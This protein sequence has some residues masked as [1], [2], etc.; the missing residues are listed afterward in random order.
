MR[1]PRVGAVSRSENKQRRHDNAAVWGC[2]SVRGSSASARTSART[3]KLEA[4]AAERQYRPVLDDRL[5]ADV[6][7]HL[8]AGL[9]LA[10]VDVE[11]PVGLV[12]DID[13]DVDD[14][15]GKLAPELG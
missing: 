14:E 1:E 6:L 12:R 10:V 5:D 8:V 11:D 7:A 2:Q 15:L 4:L 9:V 3:G 13:V